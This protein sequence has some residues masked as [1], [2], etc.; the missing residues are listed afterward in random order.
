MSTQ[1][2]LWCMTALLGVLDVC[3]CYRIGKDFMNTIF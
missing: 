1:S 3:L 2:V